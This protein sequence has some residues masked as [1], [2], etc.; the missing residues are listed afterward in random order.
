MLTRMFIGLLLA[1]VSCTAPQSIKSNQVVKA[2]YE[3]ENRVSMGTA[4]V[5][6]CIEKEGKYI[7]TLLTC[8]HFFPEENIN[9]NNF[10][11]EF[12]DG[13]SVSTGAA[14]VTS[15]KLHNTLDI[16]L[17]F[18]EYDKF[19]EPVKLNTETPIVGD[20]VLAVGFPLGIGMLTTEGLIAYN[21]KEKDGYVCSAPIC[22][23]NSGGG[24]FLEKTK[25]LIGI[26]I[27]T[28]VVPA[29]RGDML[30]AH[31]HLFIPLIAIAT[32]LEDSDE[33]SK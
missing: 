30:I 27:Q 12:Y 5:I 24:V 4:V 15:T 11:V 14:K 26:T 20:K 21:L 33:K 13:T 18:A 29:Q 19:V 16:A 22:P 7:L 3:I 2:I 1:T 23:G 8:K 28:F 9:Y 10:Y 17:L 32:W 31:M 6:D 25:E